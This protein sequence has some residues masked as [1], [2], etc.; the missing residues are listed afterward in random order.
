MDTSFNPI[1]AEQF[2]EFIREQ[3]SKEFFYGSLG[4]FSLGFVENL[5]R[6]ILDNQNPYKASKM[7]DWDSV[8]APVPPEG[9]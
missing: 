9:Y 5:N 2:T 7:I 4:D 8:G 1:T 3:Q 6:L